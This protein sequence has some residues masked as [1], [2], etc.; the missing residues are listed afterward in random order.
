MIDSY[1]KEK[2]FGGFAAAHFA[3]HRHRCKY[4]SNERDTHKKENLARCGEIEREI[5]MR[6]EEAV[7]MLYTSVC[8]GYAQKRRARRDVLLPPLGILYLDTYACMAQQFL[9][10]NFQI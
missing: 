4:R 2:R 6:E 9:G 5:R 1:H 3:L 7:C 8:R 10:I